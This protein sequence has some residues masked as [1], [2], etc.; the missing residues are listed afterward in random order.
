LP[1]PA[2]YVS[3]NKDDLPIVIDTG[4]Y[5]TITP[6][7][8]DF[9]SKPTQPGT[10]TLRSLTTVQT[11]V[12]GQGPIK[13]DIEDVNGVYKK[14][15]TTSY[16]VPEATIRL[17]SPQA[18]FKSNPSGRL[19]LDIDGITLHMPCGTDLKFPIQPGSNLPIML[20]R[21]ALHWSSS[22]NV[23]SSHKPS[24][25]TMSNILSFI[26]S[27][28]YDNFV[29]G[30]IF[31]SQHAGAMA[32]VIND[33]AVLKQANSNLSP[34][35]KELLLWHYRLGHIGIARVQSLLQKP[36]TNSFNDR[37]TRLISPSNKKSSHCHPPLCSSC[38]YAK[39]KR[40]NPPKSSVSKPLTTTG[41]S[42]DVLNAG[43]RVSVDLY[44]S[45]TNGRLPYTFGKEKAE[46]QF[47]GGAIF[48]DHSTRLIHNTHQL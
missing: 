38:Q 17:F 29:H 46:L 6:S 21:Q 37:Q 47:T 43:D 7:L 24:L 22:S 2:I 30:T 45:S 28:T 9:T 19:T 15:R 3:T 34:E 23:R 41:L 48:V 12:S 39:Q 25:N 44:C 16:Y 35:Q 4:A 33:D 1:S 32:A 11:K 31:H 5:C 36:R 26:C 20:T 40:K 18:Y 27:T 13:W 42:D 8:S 14:L 10:A